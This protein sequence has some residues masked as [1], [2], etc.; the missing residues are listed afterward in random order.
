MKVVFLPVFDGG[1]DLIVEVVPHPDVSLGPPVGLVQDG[2]PSS[3]GGS[4]L[5]TWKFSIRNVCKQQS[6]LE[7]QNIYN[8]NEFIASRLISVAQ[9]FFFGE[10][11]FKIRR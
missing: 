9:G 2:L 1:D 5:R 8:S 10:T 6:K 11:V 7:C 4:V 3:L